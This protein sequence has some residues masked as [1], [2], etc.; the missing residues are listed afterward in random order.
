MVKEVYNRI[1]NK[2]ITTAKNLGQ[3]L[4]CFICA[5][6]RVVKTQT[7]YG[8][9]E[10]FHRLLKGHLKKLPSVRTLQT[11][12]QWLTDKTKTF[13]RCVNHR[14]EEA[15]HKAWEALEEMIFGHISNLAPQ[16]AAI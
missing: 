10:H 6:F 9:I 3:V 8:R 12:V 1:Y 4:V 14:A 7:P 11:G 2:A 13:F 15:K 5:L 16:Y